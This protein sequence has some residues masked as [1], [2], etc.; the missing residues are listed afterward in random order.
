MKIGNTVKITLAVALIWLLVVQVGFYFIL[1]NQSEQVSK[2]IASSFRS[3]ALF[4]N[5]SFVARQI[6]DFEHLG[7]IS[8]AQLTMKTPTVRS[9]LDSSLNGGC[10]SNFIT[11]MGRDDSVNL[12][13]ING[14]LYNLKYFFP[15]GW[16][17]QISLWTLRIIG[18]AL[19]IS[20]QFYNYKIRQR[21]LLIFNLEKTT[22]QKLIN[23]ASQISHDIRSPLAA[24]N[25]MVKGIDQIPDTKKIIITNSINRINDIANN[26]LQGQKLNATDNELNLKDTFV[27]I[28]LNNIISEKRTLFSQNQNIDIQLRINTNDVVICQIDPSELQRIISNLINNSVEASESQKQ[29]NILITLSSNASNCEILINDTGKGIPQH[30]LEKLGQRGLTHGKENSESGSGLGVYHA[31]ET[32]K[33]MGGKIHFESEI[34]KGTQIQITFPMVEDKSQVKKTIEISSQNNIVFLDDDSSLHQVFDLKLKDIRQNNDVKVYHLN[35][36]TEFVNFIKANPDIYMSDQSW[37]LLDLDLG[38]SQPNTLEI[39]QQQ[40][41]IPKN[42]I[43]ITSNFENP[44]LTHFIGKHNLN[45]FP[46]QLYHHL[47]FASNEKCYYDWVLIDD[48]ELVHMV[49]NSSSVNLNKSLVSYYSVSEFLN[50]EKNID[51]RSNIFLDV[52]FTNG[53]NGIDLSHQ[54]HNLGFKQISLVTGYDAESLT[55]PQFINSILGKEPPEYYASQ[56]LSSVDN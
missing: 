13:T 32:I 3:E 54:I 7:L 24:L 23:Q 48:D 46:K 19:I 18:L 49:W 43:F 20:I 45:I 39:L 25:M 33:K 10:S 34:G 17:F 50:A 36:A 11:V 28:L 22:T 31:I 47:N 8:C 14:D 35:T 40:T 53:E 9:I 1:K 21:D 4:S 6:S 27:E 26:L 55:V 29:N 16:F 2:S 44:E 38:I 56:S 12:K 30:I 37:F 41:T 42:I 52:S 51:R 5:F 15:S